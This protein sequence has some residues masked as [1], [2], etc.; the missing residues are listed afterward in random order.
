MARC[1][2]STRATGAREASEEGW[3]H[4]G[5]RPGEERGQGGVNWEEPGETRQKAEP[6]THRGCRPPPAARTQD[7]ALR[8]WEGERMYG[9]VCAAAVVV[10]RDGSRENR[11]AGQ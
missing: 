11:T 4:L 10:G 8:L 7:Q 1:P 2:G 3:E 6:V 5:G 9:G